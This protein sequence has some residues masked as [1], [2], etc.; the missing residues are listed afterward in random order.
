MLASF[1]EPGGSPVQLQARH[2][3]GLRVPTQ[4]AVATEAARFPPRGA[5]PGSKA[6]GRTAH[7]GSQFPGTAREES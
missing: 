3:D 2:C 6:S 4:A 5:R 7:A 1:P